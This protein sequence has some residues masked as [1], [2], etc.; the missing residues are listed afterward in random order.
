LIERISMFVT[1]LSNRMMTAMAFAGAFVAATVL[2]TGLVAADTKKPDP[3][4]AAK[5][6]PKL[7]AVNVHDLLKGTVNV[8]FTANIPVPGFPSS[9][10][11]ERM[12]QIQTFDLAKWPE[13]TLLKWEAI[14]VLPEWSPYVRCRGI[15]QVDSLKPTIKLTTDVCEKH[16]VRTSSVALENTS[17][18]DDIVVRLTIYQGLEAKQIQVYADR[19]ELF[20]ATPDEVGKYKFA[21]VAECST[22]T[23]TKLIASSSG[24]YTKPE[25]RIKFAKDCKQSVQ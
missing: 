5:P 24:T 9:K 19:Y 13:G 22:R 2:G 3:K 7:V 12:S 16:E 20:S 18:K 8:T 4:T 14:P 1:L 10:T 15:Y 17:G 23:D 25:S 6:G 21:V 11:L